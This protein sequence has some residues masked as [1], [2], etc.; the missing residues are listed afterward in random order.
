ML[1]TL[2]QSWTVVYVQALVD[3]FVAARILL[4]FYC[5]DYNPIHC[6][7]V[8]SK[9]MTKYWMIA[10]LLSDVLLTAGYA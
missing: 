6:T 2:L 5:P 9:S 7:M 10:C 1:T 3:I 4:M 8:T